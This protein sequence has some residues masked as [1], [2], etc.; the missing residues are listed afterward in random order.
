MRATPTATPLATAHATASPIETSGC[1]GLDGG[2]LPVDS[3]HV[4]VIALRAA[5]VA[6]SVAASPINV[7]T[8]E[9]D[10]MS[11]PDPGDGAGRPF[12]ARSLPVSTQRPNRY[13][14]SAPP[15]P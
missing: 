1:S 9:L 14:R 11:P 15:A 3:F 6:P 7:Q 5:M 13:S 2:A 10:A 12:T 4:A 8:F